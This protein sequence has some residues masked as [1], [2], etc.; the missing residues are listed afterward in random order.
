[1]GVGRADG[2]LV[3]GI[4]SSVG[5]GFI[6]DVLGLTPTAAHLTF[7]VPIWLRG[8]TLPDRRLPF[9]IYLSWGQSF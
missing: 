8:T 7:G 2:G 4:G 9:E 1:V 5:I 3:T 6:A